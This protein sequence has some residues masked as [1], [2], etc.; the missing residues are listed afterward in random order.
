[1]NSSDKILFIKASK[2]FFG[3]FEEK[4]IKSPENIANR[5]CLQNTQNRPL[6]ARD[7]R[8]KYIYIFSLTFLVTKN[9]GR[10]AQAVD[11]YVRVVHRSKLDSVSP[12][13]FFN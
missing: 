13:L 2:L 12:V 1:M 7:F 11:L 5:L 10:P 9:T 4:N 3:I 8:G 6:R